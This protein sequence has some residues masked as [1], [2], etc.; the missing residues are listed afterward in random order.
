MAGVVTLVVV[1]VG[2]GPAPAQAPPALPVIS[3]VD[4]A[5][6]LDATA[7]V[8]CDGVEHL[9]V[10][11]AGVVFLER[12]DPPTSAE[13]TVE[14]GIAYAGDLAD[15]LVGAPTSLTIEA[16]AYLPSVRFDLPVEASGS[17]TISLTPG[18]G[19]ELGS[20]SSVAATVDAATVVPFDCTAPLDLPPGHTDQVIGVGGTPADLPEPP[21]LDAYR[22]EI[23]GDRPPGLTF[24]G[25]N[26][27]WSGAAT[28]PG[29]Y[30]LDVRSYQAWGFPGID[31]SV[32]LYLA[33]AEVTIVVEGAAGPADRPPTGVAPPATPVPAAARFTG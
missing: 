22:Y 31:P 20:T 2:G 12:E 4:L 13:E 18:T 24:D 29:T 26:G 11:P 5:L 30:V 19:Y 27:R 23:V 15:D 14:V 28:T 8:D 25:L 3:V 1:L 6:V 10:L 32:R 21:V 16:G 7:Y 33:S 17:L 9:A